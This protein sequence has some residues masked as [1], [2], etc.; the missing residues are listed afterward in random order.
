MTPEQARKILDD[1]SKPAEQYQQHSHPL[2]VMQ[3]HSHALER[4]LHRWMKS[5]GED[6]QE[7]V[8]AGLIRDF[9]NTAAEMRNT[10]ASLHANVEFGM[11]GNEATDG[12][13]PEREEAHGGRS[14]SD[15]SAEHPERA[16]AGANAHGAAA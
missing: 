1:F 14:T 11:L 12:E 6:E 10:L 9:W 4:M 3:Y 15:D 2:E 13:D 7:F 16:E 5:V 8:D